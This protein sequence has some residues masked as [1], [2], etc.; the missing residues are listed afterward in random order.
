MR[1]RDLILTAVS[2]WL[3]SS[4]AEAAMDQVIRERMPGCRS[5][6]TM[7]RVFELVD[8]K[9]LA[10]ADRVFSDGIRTGECKVFAEGEKVVIEERQASSGLSRI[11]DT[12]F[13]TPYWVTNH[14]VDP[15]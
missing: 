7:L 2:A 12:G 15:R 6:D 1:R 10:A 3:L 13:P 5:R 4:P 9:D 11:H 14:T 8:Q